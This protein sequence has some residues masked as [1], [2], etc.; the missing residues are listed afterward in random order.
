VG[1]LWQVGGFLLFAVTLASST[2]KTECHDIAV[3]LLKVVLN[4]ITHL[5]IPDEGYSRITAK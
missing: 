5:T 1:D 4:T 3:I 2:N